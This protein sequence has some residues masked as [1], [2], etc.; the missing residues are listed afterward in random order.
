MIRF[1]QIVI[2]T[3]FTYQDVRIR[4][5]VYGTLQLYKMPWPLSVVVRVQELPLM[6]AD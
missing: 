1:Q 2:L 3:I 4:M 5:Y 6:P